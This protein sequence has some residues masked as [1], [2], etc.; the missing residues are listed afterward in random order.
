MKNTPKSSDSAII[1]TL[2][3]L[4]RDIDSEDGVANLAIY[5]AADRFEELISHNHKLSQ[6]CAAVLSADEPGCPTLREARA[7]CAEALKEVAE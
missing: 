6:A 3:V 5:E 4:A 1:K 2:R 7:L